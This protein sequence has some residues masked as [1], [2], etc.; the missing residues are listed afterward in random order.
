MLANVL[1][2]RVT[3]QART[4]TRDDH[5]GFTES[6][7]AV[8]R[9]LT[10]MPAR[11]RPLA[12]RDLERARQIDP[13]ISHELTL[14]AWATYAADL[15]GGRVRVVYHPTDRAADDRV[16]EVVTPAVDVDE[17]HAE[18]RVQAREVA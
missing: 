9:A 12:G 18:I 10:R 17:R 11:V 4:E 3:V 15:D 14:R 13:R 2:S 1:R 7:A 6:W 8:S 16:F 5:D